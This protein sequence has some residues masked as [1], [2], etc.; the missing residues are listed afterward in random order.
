MLISE[1]EGLKFDSYIGQ[2]IVHE[3]ANS[4]HYHRFPDSLLRCEVDF[5]ELRV[6]NLLSANSSRNKNQFKFN[7]L[8]PYTVSAVFYCNHILIWLQL[9]NIAVYH[10]AYLNE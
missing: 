4:Y 5:R 6:N 2:P 8:L 9:Y 10:A 1:A 3:V 7:I